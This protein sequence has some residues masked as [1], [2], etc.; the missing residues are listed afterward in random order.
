MLN[1]FT[2]NGLTS[3]LA[4][5]EISCRE[6]ARACLDRA[7]AVESKVHA[8]LNLS[9]ERVLAHADMMDQEIRREGYPSGRPLFGIPI[10]IKD[11]IAV[12]DEPLTCGSKILGNFQAPYDAT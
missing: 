10:A 2:I 7:D 6:L 12:K 3:K 4:A 8:F 5:K 11:V 1:H 9:P